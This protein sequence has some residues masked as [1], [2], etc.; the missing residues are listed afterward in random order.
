MYLFLKDRLTY[1]PRSVGVTDF[2][3]LVKV[4][5]MFYIVRAVRRIAMRM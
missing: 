2:R 1:Q 3:I 4:Q 5:Q